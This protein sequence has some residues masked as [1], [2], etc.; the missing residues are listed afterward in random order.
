MSFC[1]ER[2]GSNV[3]KPAAT[4]RL[5]YGPIPPPSNRADIRKP[6]R[7]GSGGKLRPQAPDTKPLTACPRGPSLKLCTV[8]ERSL[9]LCEGRSLS[10][11]AHSQ[12]GWGTGQGQRRTPDP[13]PW[14]SLVT[15]AV[16]DMALIFPRKHCCLESVP[17]G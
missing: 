14:D 3:C 13:V 11:Q 16:M 17:V 9:G 4:C 15:R 5:P 7:G 8:S 2:V 6:D 10:R 1:Q 12:Y